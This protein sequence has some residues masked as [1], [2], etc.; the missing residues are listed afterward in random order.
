MWRKEDVDQAVAAMPYAQYLGISFDESSQRFALPFRQDL[1]GNANLPAV[2]GGA[3][4]GFIE[5]SA[6]L[7]L[8]LTRNLQVLPKPIDFAVNFL[9]V[10]KAQTCFAKCEL[11][12]QGRRL[13]LLEVRCWQGDLQVVAGRGHF[14]IE[15]DA[16]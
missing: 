10:A 6:I 9:H 2:H 12:R 16:A 4:G 3:L 5:S 8:M 7:W 15:S 13:V 14:L 1:V 11:L